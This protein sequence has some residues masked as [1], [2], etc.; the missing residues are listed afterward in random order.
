MSPPTSTMANNPLH[1]FMGFTDRLPFDSRTV[2]QVQ[3]LRSVTFVTF[4][5]T[6]LRRQHH[7]TNCKSRPREVAMNAKES[8]KRQ[9]TRGCSA[10]A[11]RELR[12]RHRS[13]TG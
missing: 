7:S 11:M 4:P 1:V 9:P 12:P 13:A 8:Q 2:Y 6:L 5:K 10:A 3:P